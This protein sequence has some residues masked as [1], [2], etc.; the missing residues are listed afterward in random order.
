MAHAQMV[1][2]QLHRLFVERQMQELSDQQLL[3]FFA[4]DRS[5]DAFAALVER[6]GRLVMG[7]CRH[8]LHHAQDAEDAFQATF[9]VLACKARSIRKQEALASWLHGVAYRMALKAKRDAGKRRAQTG[10]PCL[11]AQ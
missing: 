11:G 9:L 10:Q 5:E 1:V 6:H 8:V 4:Q 2:A 7:V 3:H